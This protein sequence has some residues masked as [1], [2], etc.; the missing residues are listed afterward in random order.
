MADIFLSSPP[1]ILG[2]QQQ[3]DYSTRYA[4]R[5]SFDDMDILDS[6]EW[7]HVKR[8]QT[9]ED[10]AQSVY[11]DTAS[12]SGGGVR[13]PSGELVGDQTQ[14][15]SQGRLALVWCLAG[16]DYEMSELDSDDLVLGSK[17]CLW[18]S[19]VALHISLHSGIEVALMCLDSLR[20]P[21]CT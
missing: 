20:L 18:S 19:I 10:V 5:T 16:I 1:L 11:V 7:I 8:G 3:Q 2:L 21:S 15:S 6:G 17:L 13:P 4:S 9:A 12:C 14:C